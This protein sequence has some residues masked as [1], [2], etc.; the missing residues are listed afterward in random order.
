MSSH[1]PK[2]ADFWCLDFVLTIIRHLRILICPYSVTEG[3]GGKQSNQYRQHRLR[4]T[5]PSAAIPSFFP[6]IHLLAVVSPQGPKIKAFILGI[7]RESSGEE[8]GSQQL[9]L[10]LVRSVPSACIMSAT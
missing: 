9:E 6:R 7:D 2:P 5:R 8:E 3:T 1:E 10:D 4:S